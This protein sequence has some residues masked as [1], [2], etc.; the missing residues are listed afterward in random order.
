VV[1]LCETPV[2]QPQLSRSARRVGGG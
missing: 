2:D 1:E